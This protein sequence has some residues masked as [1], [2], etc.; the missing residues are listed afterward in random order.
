MRGL[1]YVR[2]CRGIGRT[3]DSLLGADDESEVDDLWEFL[4]VVGEVVGRFFERLWVGLGEAGWD[5]ET[6]AL[7]TKSGT[8]VRVLGDEEG[9]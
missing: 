1:R 2:S 3:G 4:D 7:E 5:L 6:A 8:R 9:L